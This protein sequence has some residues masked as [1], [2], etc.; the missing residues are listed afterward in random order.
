MGTIRKAA[1]EY[2]TAVLVTTEKDSQRLAGI[3]G[4]AKILKERMFFAPIK[5]EFVSEGDQ[6]RFMQVLTS[7]LCK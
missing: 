2:P 4:M 1:E 7:C 5:A 3:P 6:E